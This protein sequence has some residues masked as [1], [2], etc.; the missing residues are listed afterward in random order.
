MPKAK[1]SRRRSNNQVNQPSASGGTR[2][3]TTTTETSHPAARRGRPRRQVTVLL[4]QDDPPQPE[5]DPP[6]DEELEL[7]TMTMANLVSVIQYQF[8]RLQR[9]PPDAPGNNHSDQPHGSQD[10]NP[11]IPPGGAT[12]PTP[13]STT[14][15]VSGLQNILVLV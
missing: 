11:V 12:V 3:R 1:A 9:T 14:P 10:T 7:S 15:T 2:S 6:Q 8:T 13:V 4:P 5:D